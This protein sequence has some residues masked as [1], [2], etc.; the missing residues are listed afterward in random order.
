MTTAIPGLPRRSRRAATALAALAATAV[1][2]SVATRPVPAAAQGGTY[3]QTN[4]DS[5][6]AGR[7]QF[8]DADL[9]NPW[10]IVAGPTSPFWV[11]DNN[12]GVTTLYRGDG[13]KLSLT[14]GTTTIP[15]VNIPAPGGGAGTPTG[16]V[17]SRGKGFTVT[18]GTASGDSAFIFATEDGTIVSWAP[19]V[20]F[21]NGIIA[22]DRSTTPDAQDGAVYKGLALGSNAGSNLLYATN[23]R[24]GTVDVFGSAFAPVDLGP[25]AFRDPGIPAGYAPFGIAAVP[26]GILVSYAVQNAQRHDDVSGQG[27]GFIDLYSTA[28]TLVR[29]LVQHGQLDSPWGM[30]M[31]PASG[32][33]QFSG[34]LLVGNFGNGEI[35]AFLPDGELAGAL[36]GPSGQRL[37]DSGVWGLSFGNGAA[38]GPTTTL[39]F[40]AGINDEANGLFGSIVAG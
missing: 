23:F 14:S 27:H 32:F 36:R 29:R 33:G 2:G 20:D 34:D 39:Y 17:F 35:N 21:A 31:A 9:V 28:G 37:V 16:V 22:V 15:H 25:S 10:G 26:Q 11:S 13:T 24:A 8:Q 5:D 3:V 12:A 6:L 19:A 7:A 4:L 38:A 40:T 18:S 30:V 1:A